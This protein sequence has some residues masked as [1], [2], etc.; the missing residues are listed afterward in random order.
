MDGATQELRYYWARFD[1]LSIEDGILGIR[2]AVDDDSKT[3]FRALV[4]RSARQYI[5]EQPHA[6][7]SGGHFGV[8]KTIDKL[9]QRVHW[10]SIAKSVRE[11][12][13][14]CPTCNRHK[15]NKR[16]KGPLQPIYTGAPFERGA[17]DIVGPMPRT[18]RGNR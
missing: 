15:S 7:P 4:P 11:W 9:K 16:N 2:T 5:L 14:K 6:S 17:M 8:Q 18:V 3:V 10:M 12:C 1:E 13:S